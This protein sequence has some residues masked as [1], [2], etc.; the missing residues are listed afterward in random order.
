MFKGDSLFP[1]LVT[2]QKSS[3]DEAY[4]CRW[5][6]GLSAPRLQLSP[7]HPRSCKRKEKAQL[8]LGRRCHRSHTELVASEKGAVVELQSAPA[9]RRAEFRD[10]RGREVTG[11]MSSVMLLPRA[12]PPA[13]P[14]AAY[15]QARLPRSNCTK[16]DHVS[17]NQLCLVNP[18]IDFKAFQRLKGY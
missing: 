16:P 15:W 5:Q 3:E 14:Q 13:P 17:Q 11:D 18:Q 12:G 6:K 2:S 9:R 10:A 4:R 8:L 7:Q 1:S